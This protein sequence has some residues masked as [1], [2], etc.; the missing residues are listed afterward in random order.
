MVVGCKSVHHRSPT[1]AAA[2]EGASYTI[3][4]GCKPEKDSEVIEN[5]AIEMLL[6]VLE[7][8]KP[9]ISEYFKAMDYLHAGYMM[10]WDW[11]GFMEKVSETPLI[12]MDSPVQLLEWHGAS[13]LKI[14]V[15][16]KIHVVP[17]TYLVPRAASR[18]F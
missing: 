18:L 1:V 11:H 3:H 12:H 16:S 6:T 14:R 17:R 8:T 2:L 13:H 7:T 15:E 5:I 4:C 9:K 10:G